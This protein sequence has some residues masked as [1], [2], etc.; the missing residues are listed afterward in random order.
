M[1]T[2]RSY[3]E[4]LSLT[5]SDRLLAV[6]GYLLQ[7]PMQTVAISLIN[8]RHVPPMHRYDD[9]V[10]TIIH[11][12]QQAIEALQQ[13]LSHANDEIM[14]LTNEKQFMSGPEKTSDEVDATFV[15]SSVPPMFV[16]PK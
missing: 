1:K 2:R 11:N 4:L 10:T 8:E 13:A 15:P 9:D 3:D 5:F 14:R 6:C 7:T 16:E 12:N